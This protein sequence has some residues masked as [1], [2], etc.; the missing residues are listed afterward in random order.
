[1]QLSCLELSGFSSNSWW[2][3]VVRLRLNGYSLLDMFKVLN[4]QIDFS[5]YVM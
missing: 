2:L 4:K 5:I 3:S 1:M